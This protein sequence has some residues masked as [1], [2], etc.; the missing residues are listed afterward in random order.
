MHYTDFD[1]VEDG[2]LVGGGDAGEHVQLA[3]DGGDAVASPARLQSGTQ[4]PVP[5]SATNGGGGGSAHGAAPSQPVAPDLVAVLAECYDVDEVGE[6]AGRRLAL[7]R[8][9]QA[10]DHARSE[11]T[12]RHTG[13]HTEQMGSVLFFRRP[14][15]G[16]WPNR[17]RALSIYIYIYLSLIHI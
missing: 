3:S 4:R 6:R 11:H 16:S 17:E 15:S 13:T 5:G 12:G 9:R 14:R 2:G 7:Q 8:R 10:T 1:G